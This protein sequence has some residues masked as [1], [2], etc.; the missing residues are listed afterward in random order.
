MLHSPKAEEGRKL[1]RFERGVEDP[2]ILP[3]KGVEGRLEDFC[4]IKATSL[5]TSFPAYTHP[6]GIGQEKAKTRGDLEECRRVEEAAGFEI[7]FVKE[8]RLLLAGTDRFYPF[9]ARRLQPLR[10]GMN[11]V[12]IA[13]DKVE[14]TTIILSLT[15]SRLKNRCIPRIFWLT[16]IFIVVTKY[17]NLFFPFTFFLNGSHIAFGYELIIRS[18]TTDFMEII[19]DKLPS[20]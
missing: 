12:H 19:R 7:K 4:V 14:K 3:L 9:P 18:E 11:C 15:V 2:V 17:S 20:V 1:Y 8:G 16:A 6:M 13:L 5:Y 10:S